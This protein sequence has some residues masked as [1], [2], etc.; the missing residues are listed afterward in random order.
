MSKLISGNNVS[1]KTKSTMKT[2]EIIEYGMRKI[3]GGKSV[4]TLWDQQ[5]SE[6]IY[7]SMRFYKGLI[8]GTRVAS[9]GSLNPCSRLEANVR[10]SVMRGL[11]INYAWYPPNLRPY[12]IHGTWIV[13]PDVTV[14]AYTIMPSFSTAVIKFTDE[15]SQSD[16]YNAYELFDLESPS[17]RGTDI[18]RP[19]SSYG[20]MSMTGRFSVVTQGILEDMGFKF[21]PPISIHLDSSRLIFCVKHDDEILELT[22][23][24]HSF[25][26]IKTVAE[27]ALVTDKAISFYTRRE[28]R[29]RN[30][31]YPSLR[32][33]CEGNIKYV[34][35]IDGIEPCYRKYLT[36]INKL[37]SSTDMVLRLLATLE[38]LV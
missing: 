9:W 5:V 20:P 37:F 27:N 18:L 29:N 14:T 19:I 31:N 1:K 6:T 4:L 33:T 12:V 25:D 21:D 30:T 38:P 13:C 36:A 17:T 34:G 11:G 26:V 8:A 28:N 24:V 3:S 7:S 35:V 23:T 16:M 22:P 32:L 10:K 15:M 2:T